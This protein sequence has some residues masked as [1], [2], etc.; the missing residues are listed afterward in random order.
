MGKQI[1]CPVDVPK[2]KRYGVYANA[3]RVLQD[4]AEFLLDFLVFSEQDQTAKVVSRLRVNHQMLPAV[5]DRLGATMM[6]VQEQAKT[7]TRRK[8][9]DPVPIV[10]PLYMAKPDGEVH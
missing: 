2:S 3:F 6:E 1:S 7:K 8:Q 9:D 5:R 4:G 10:L